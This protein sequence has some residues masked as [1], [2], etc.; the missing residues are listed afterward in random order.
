MPDDGR[1]VP[2][3]SLADGDADGALRDVRP[4]MAALRPE[5]IRRV[6]VPIPAAASVILGAVPFLLSLREEIVRL[7]RFPIRCLDN[8]AKYALAAWWAHERDVT[9]EDRKRAMARLG[10]RARELLQLLRVSAPP[11]AFVGAIGDVE[12]TELARKRG[13]AALAG[14]LAKLTRAYRRSWDEIAGKSLVREEHLV[15]AETVA[16]KLMAIGSLGES[17]EVDQ[18]A[19]HDDRVRAYTLMDRAY[20]W[21][22]RAAAYLCADDPEW[23]SKVPPYRG[24]WSGPRRKGAPPSGEGSGEPEGAPV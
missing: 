18:V 21:C 23:E 20:E 8:L 6:N 19:A 10:K 13:P 7:P 4:E 3:A 17:A 5:E 1:A 15:E 24:R 11:L 22:R 12:S 2:L 9:T 16:G 14:N